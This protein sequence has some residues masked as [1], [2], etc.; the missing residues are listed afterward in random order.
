MYIM[1]TGFSGI[2]CGWAQPKY[3]DVSM[4]TS[5]ARNG[6]EYYKLPEERDLFVWVGGGASAS[7]R[8][9]ESDVKVCKLYKCVQL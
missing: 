5:K 7:T 8:R 2:E 4:V 6:F 9:A 3:Y 1:N